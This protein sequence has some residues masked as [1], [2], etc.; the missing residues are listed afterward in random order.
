MH[1][2]KNG[3]YEIIKLCI[4]KGLITTQNVNIRC[5]SR[6]N[7]GINSAVKLAKRYNHTRI[8]ELFIDEGLIDKELILKNQLYF[9][10]IIKK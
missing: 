4:D 10:V 1:L 2:C 9:I 6:C 3:N 8:I 5:Q 7:Q